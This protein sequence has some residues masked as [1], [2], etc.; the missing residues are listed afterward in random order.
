MKFLYGNILVLLA[1]FLFVSGEAYSAENR[2][3]IA[4]IDTGIKKG[5]KIDPFLC[6]FGHKSFVEGE[7]VTDRHGHGTNVAGLISDNLD[8][9]KHCLLIL[10]YYKKGANGQTS[11][12]RSNEA[13]QYAIDFGVDYINYSNN[14]PEDNKGEFKMLMKA[15]T[16]GI[17][18]AIAAGNESNKQLDVRCDAFPACYR[19]NKFAVHVVSTVDL[20]TSNQGEEIVTHKEL[21]CGGVPRMCGTS[22]ATAIHMGKWVSGKVK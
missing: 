4:V 2:I 5:E 11:L 14:G 13:I 12:R 16:S 1:L 9:K 3:K 7:D 22:Q 8:P 17:K 18:M 21:G 19:L 20:E 10:K 6:K 15:V